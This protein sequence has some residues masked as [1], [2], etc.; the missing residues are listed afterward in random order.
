M[1]AEI[2]DLQALTEQFMN[3]FETFKATN[4][5]AFKE[6][7]AYLDAITAEMTADFSKLKADLRGSIDA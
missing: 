1:G 3:G 5:K 7:L 4:H 6:V 2:D